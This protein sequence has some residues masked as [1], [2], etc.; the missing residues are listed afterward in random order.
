MMDNGDPLPFESGVSC[1]D[2]FFF[3]LSNFQQKYFL[4]CVHFGF[5]LYH[6]SRPVQALCK[7]FC[8]VQ[9]FF[10]HY[11]YA[12]SYYL[13]IYILFVCWFPQLDNPDEQA[14]QIRRELDGRLQMADQI[15]RVKDM[16]EWIDWMNCRG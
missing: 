12:N 9:F 13:R 14:A 15:A 11:F 1:F 5:S 16:N 7:H 10:C 4:C 2:F 3:V 8:K 6:A